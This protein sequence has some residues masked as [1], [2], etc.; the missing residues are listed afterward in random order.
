MDCATVIEQLI[1]ANEAGNDL[2]SR[3]LEE[4]LRHCSDCRREWR[5]A[6][7]LRALRERPTAPPRPDLFDEITGNVATI[8]TRDTGRGQFWLGTAVGGLIAAGLATLVLTF[9]VFNNMPTPA[10]TAPAVAMALGTP[11]DINIAIDAERDLV[12]TTVYVTLTDGFGIAGYGEERTLSWQTDLRS[13]V[14]K[15]T[16]PIV[17]TATGT[18]QLV[19]RLEHEGSERLFRIDLQAKG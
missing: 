4:H 15:L 3:R 17:A 11:Q 2:E 10:A 13:G 18:G 8:G 9:G 1:T 19:V 16:L 6:T 12:G 14:N 5:A 7:A